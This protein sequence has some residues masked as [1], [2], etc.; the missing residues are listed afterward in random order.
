MA[1]AD[2]EAALLKN[3][4]EALTER[5]QKLEQEQVALWIEIAFRV[6]P[7]FDLDKKPMFRCHWALQNQPLMGASKPAEA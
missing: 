4:V 5:R 2:A 6:A 7:H 3:K 1:R